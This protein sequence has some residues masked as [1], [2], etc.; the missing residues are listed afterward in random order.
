MARYL[1][2]LGSA[3][4]IA[5]LQNYAGSAVRLRAS[6][7]KLNV[8]NTA[9]MTADSGYSFAAAQADRTF[10]GRI[11]ESAVGAHLHNT[12]ARNI[13]VRYWRDSQTEVDFVLQRGHELVAIEVKSR[14]PRAA[15]IRG[16]WMRLR[17]GSAG[18]Q[19][20]VR[21][22]WGLVVSRSTSSSRRR[23]PRGSR[24]HESGRSH[25]HRDS[26]CR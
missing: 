11:V 10:W 14:A 24:K 20:C 13:R 22:S 5:G 4:L 19:A 9:L 21:C 12:A 7:P 26:S 18:L 2:L 16:G 3:G 17:N 8:L 23:R 25:V 15:P 1:E 6:S